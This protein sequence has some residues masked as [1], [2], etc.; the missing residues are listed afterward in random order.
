MRP[1]GGLLL[2]FYADYRGRRKALILAVLIMSLAT[3]AIGLLPTLEQGGLISPCLLVFWVLLVF[4]CVNKSNESP[5]FLQEV[6]KIF[7]TSLNLS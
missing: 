5:V 4:I 7:V 2:G 1:L 6:T 3:L